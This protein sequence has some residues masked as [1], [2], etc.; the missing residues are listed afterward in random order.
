MVLPTPE[1]AATAPTGPNFY[2]DARLAGLAQ[3]RRVVFPCI[4]CKL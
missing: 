1:N 2:P 4:A 3:A